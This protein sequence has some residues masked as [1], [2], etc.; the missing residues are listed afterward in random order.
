MSETKIPNP[1]SVRHPR[2]GHTHRGGRGRTPE[3]IS[4][5]GMIQRCHNPNHNRYPVYGAR[6]IVVCDRWKS[7]FISFLSDMGPKPTPKHTIDRFP[8]QTGNYE[9]GN[10]RWA[11]IKEQQRNRKSNTILEF[12]GEKRC[13]SEWAEIK[14]VPSHVIL[15][16]I[17]A[18]WPIGRI[19]QE[20]VHKYV[21]KP[22]S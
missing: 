20:P 14:G 12:N 4:W 21:R 17:K 9:P 19:M 2:H 10:C 5:V 8:N 6:G 13:V 15:G 7:S 22:N 3:Y 1:K 11:T 18:G 16:R